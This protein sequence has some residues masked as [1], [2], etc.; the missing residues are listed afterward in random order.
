MD[1]EYY[2][3]I[4]NFIIVIAAS[5]Y[6]YTRRKIFKPTRKPRRFGV[7]P[8]FQQRK[9]LGEYATLF[10]EIKVGDPEI[11][12]KYTRMSSTTFDEL[13]EL[14]KPHL[15]RKSPLAISPGERLAFT[16]R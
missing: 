3:T 5:Y 11:F 12:F 13:L 8:L 14:L 6:R 1:E 15:T 9:A 2:Y 7:R 16:L 4:L 10:Q